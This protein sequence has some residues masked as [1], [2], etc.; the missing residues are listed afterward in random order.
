MSKM[1]HRTIS[2]SHPESGIQVRPYSVAFTKE[3]VF[4]RGHSDWHGLLYASA[5]VLSV[6]SASGTWVVPAHRAVWVPSGTQRTI[7]VSAG[8]VMRSLYF[9]P[10]VTRS[11]PR[12]CCVVNV[13]PLLRELINHTNDV[14]ML[15]RAIP[16]HA[17]LI[18]VLID[19]LRVMKAVPL[20]LPQPADARAIKVAE[21]LRTN[22]GAKMSL[23]RIAVHAGASARTIERLFRSQTNMTFAKWRERLR[24]LHALRLLAAGEAV[25]NIALDLG[26][27]SPS[28]FI[29]MFRRAFG[30]TPSRYYR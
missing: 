27:A 5:G 26:Y 7:E 14:G 8:L 6:R 13:P 21:Y 1:R 11:L 12:D 2:P 22:P 18:G 19:Q 16:E 30:T 4:A 23:G 15:N 29:A 24:L 9:K 10:G 25:T 17:R 28:G 3:Y 20:Q